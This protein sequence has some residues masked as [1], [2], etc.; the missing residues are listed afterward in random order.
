[1]ATAEHREP[2][3]IERFTYVCLGARGGEIPARD[4]TK[5]E[6]PRYG[7]M[8]ASAGCGHDGMLGDCGCSRSAVRELDVVLQIATIIVMEFAT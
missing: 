7:R 4:S 5:R 2:Y 6:I 1:M 8:S 3:E